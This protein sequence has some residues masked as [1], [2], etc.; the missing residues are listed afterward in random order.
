MSQNS[1]ITQIANLALQ[2]LTPDN[3]KIILRVTTAGTQQGARYEWAYTHQRPHRGM[4]K[5]I[6]TAEASQTEF[7]MLKASLGLLKMRSLL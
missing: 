4:L 2:A 3:L 5:S 6:N 1:S 7:T